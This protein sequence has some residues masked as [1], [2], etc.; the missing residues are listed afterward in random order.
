MIMHPTYKI[1]LK[2]IKDLFGTKKLNVVDYGCG[3]GVLI[4]V[5]GKNRV[6]QYL[7]L[8]TSRDA[9]GVGQQKYGNDPK[10]HFKIIKPNNHLMLGRANTCDVVVLIG[11]LQYLND[12]EITH[13]LNESRRILKPGGYFLASTVVDDPFYMFINLYRFVFPNRYI[14][15]RGMTRQLQRAGF[16]SVESKARGLI[17]GPLVSHGLVIPF[18]AFDHYV[19]RVR[20]RIGPFGSLVRLLA[21]P[22]MYAELLIGIDKG[23][24]LYIVAQKT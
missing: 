20:G 13:V 14:N 7:G 4:D 9:V 3:N 21:F 8:D 19:L 24:T 18:D 12:Q 16:R 2:T 17:I 10:F 15:R 5:L 6:N 11:V 23:Y 1:W 22:F